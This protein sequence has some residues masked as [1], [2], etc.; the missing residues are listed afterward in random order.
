[1][2]LYVKIDEMCRVERANNSARISDRIQLYAEGTKAKLKNA[3]YA[4]SKIRDL[5]T[6]NDA[7]TDS[8]EPDFSI[9][10]KLQFHVDS[11]FAFLYSAFDIISHA[12]NQKYRLTRDER[13]VSFDKVKRALDSR[14]QGSPIQQAYY[15][16]SK[17]IFFKNLDN[18]RNCSTHRRQ[19]CIRTTRIDVTATA[20]YSTSENFATMVHVLCD[21]PLS[22]APRFTQ[23]RE[24]VAYCS[25]VLTLGMSEIENII[26]NL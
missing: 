13:E 24:V 7:F 4:L 9:S 14:H 11:F 19:I 2:S 17:K 12:I 18:Y 26:N 16:I 22:L 8:T 5:S 20:G 25:R 3:E 15:E 1:M 21:N 10:E 6:R 23:R